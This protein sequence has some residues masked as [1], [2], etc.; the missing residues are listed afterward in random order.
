MN[1]MTQ[2][3]DLATM[4]MRTPVTNFVVAVDQAVVKL[5]TA[6]G[7]VKDKGWSATLSYKTYQQLKAQGV[8]A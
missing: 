5:T 1:A 8:M 2:A 3:F 7:K 4:D 6:Q